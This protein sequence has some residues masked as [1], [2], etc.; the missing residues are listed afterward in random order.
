MKSEITKRL[1]ITGTSRGIG[2][3][4]AEYYLRKGYKVAG[5]SR[6]SA[7]VEH[8]N[9]MHYSLSVSDEKSVVNMVKD[10]ARKWGGIDILINN[11]GMASMNHIILTPL[12]TVKDIL[13]TNLVGTFLFV[14]E[15]AK[16]MLKHKYGRIV[17]ISTV[18][19]P[20]SLDGE[21]AYVASKS[22]VE[23][24]TR[25]AARE[26]G[27]YNITVNAVGIA[28]LK[29]RLMRTVPKEK[30]DNI[31]RLMTIPRLTEFRD[32]VNVI[33]FFIKEESDFITGQVIYLG[34]VWH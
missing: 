10:V 26:L 14:R 32:V 1:I 17:N 5:C 16:I 33:D 11:A 3:Y 30:I 23:A 19:V 15:A 8:D 22:A 28:P 2:K 9:Y 25:V 27:P 7:S 31:L 21:G 12:K 13:E 29:T 6:S 4:L 34:G 24:F 20:L 18:A